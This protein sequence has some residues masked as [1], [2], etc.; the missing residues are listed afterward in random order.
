MVDDAALLKTCVSVKVVSVCR[1]EDAYH[2]M[3]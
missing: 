1:Q 2:F 3:S